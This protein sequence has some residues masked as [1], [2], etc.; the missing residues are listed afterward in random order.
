MRLVFL[1][2]SQHRQKS[3]E[4]KIPVSFCAMLTLRWTSQGVFKP[5]GILGPLDQLL[6]GVSMAEHLLYMIIATKKI[7]PFTDWGMQNRYKI[8]LSC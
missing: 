8:V 2:G 7:S 5:K 1:A 4:H 6:G 3:W